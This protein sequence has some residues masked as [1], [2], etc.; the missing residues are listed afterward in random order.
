MK[1]TKVIIMQN[2]KREL[3]CEEY[4]SSKFILQAHNQTY[5][6]SIK[7]AHDPVDHWFEHCPLGGIKVQDRRTCH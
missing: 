2:R 1:K 3:K 7:K 5:N 6:E 4:S